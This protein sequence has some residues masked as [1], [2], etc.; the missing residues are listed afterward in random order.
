MTTIVD[1]DF[2]QRMAHRLRERRL[3]LGLSLAELAGRSGVSR[4]MIGKVETGTASPTAGVL[5]RLCGGLGITMSALMAAVERE[6]VVLLRAA[7]QP[8]WHDPATGLVRVAVSPVTPG[9][10]VDVARLELP[11]G[12]VVEYPVPPDIG[13]AQH[14]VGIA[15]LLRLTIGARS[16]DVGP[17]DCVA[18]RVDRPTRLEAVDDEPA[19]Y[20]VIIQRTRPAGRAGD[21]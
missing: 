13:Y 12:A 2:G 18:A 11:A 16:F 7:D 4:A 9:S 5:G 3:E 15:G 6:D 8:R 20:L 17:G 1:V 14:L 19:E 21:A 10:D